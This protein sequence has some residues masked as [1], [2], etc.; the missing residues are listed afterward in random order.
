MLENVDLNL[1]V[2]KDEYENLFNIY[3]EKMGSLQR[4]IRDAGI[5]VIIL[6]E[7][8][9]GALRGTMINRLL[10]TMDPRGFRVYS[11]TKLNE[12]QKN[13]PFLAPFW[14]ELPPKGAFSIYHRS[15]YF[16][17]LEE[18]V[19]ANKEKNVGSLENSYD[20]INAYERQLTDDGYLI[21]KIFTH[22]S[23][24]KQKKNLKKLNKIYGKEWQ[25][26]N[27][28][29]SESQ[30]YEDYYGVYEE[31][32]AATDKPN[33]PWHL[34]SAEDLRYA[35]LEIFRV[36][37]AELE[38]GLQRQASGGETK[39]E[40]FDLE[41][42]NILE[43]FDLSQDIDKKTYSDQLKK[44]QKRLRVLQFELYKHKI[45]SIIVFEGWDASGKGGVIQ[46][47]TEAFD[48]LGYQVIPV[49]AP[50]AAESQYHYLWRFWR[51]L[52]E[53]G[54]LTIFD[55]SW[56]GRVLVERVEGFAKKDEWQRAYQEINETEAQWVEHG[57]I[58]A[59][60]WL[61]IDKDE[62]YA[63]FTARE[64]DENKIWKITE[65]DWRNRDKWDE[66]EQ[67]VNEMLFRTDTKY[68][69]WTVVEANSKYY[70]RLKV[71]QTIIS[72]FEKALKD[73]ED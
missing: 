45:A 39:K 57:I 41:V 21:I 26:L 9:R 51:H 13:K 48:P 55:R 38:A 72:L 2:D 12:E 34:V 65:E 44:Y 30:D 62:Q 54:E 19:G 32:F 8:W 59:K 68:A 69:P 47:L 46:R 66:Y 1:A 18:E 71:L 42:P 3:A 20:D 7:G 43:G 17:K 70:A 52:P 10:T 50:N 29:A 16:P 49:G 35:Q 15:W 40:V 58:M 56:Y 63:R 31:M 60:F 6:F 4:Q 25:K 22:L 24:K 67:A 64:N 5:P 61:Q 27:P 23:P 36:L 37:F 73:K 53:A 28:D 33:S 11:A 14:E